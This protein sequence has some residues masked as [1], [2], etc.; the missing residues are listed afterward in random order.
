MDLT[1]ELQARK[2]REEHLSALPAMVP[3]QVLISFTRPT[4]MKVMRVISR[5]WQTT[6][7]RGAAE[8]S[9]NVAVVGLH[10]LHRM[11]HLA[12]RREWASSREM[13]DSA[14]RTLRKAAK[15]DVQMEEFY[16][17]KREIEDVVP[18]LV[19][20][21]SDARTASSDA[22]AK[23]L[24]KSKS[25]SK[26]LLLSGRLKTAAVARRRVKKELQERVGSFGVEARY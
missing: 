23:L 1:F 18:A 13:L 17:L 9:V 21:E 6:R 14:L 20:A 15:T 25:A 19:R 4:G 12:G 2:M 16:S 11:A 22:T 5:N 7:N 24:Y 8:E 3:I 26:N 10:A